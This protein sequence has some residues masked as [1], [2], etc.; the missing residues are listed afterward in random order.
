MYDIFAEKRAIIPELI[1]V[2]MQICKCIC[3]PL[4]TGK[5]SGLVEYEDSRCVAT[6][7][8]SLIGNRFLL[9]APKF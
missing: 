3:I 4:D 6:P 1:R 7:G 2:D 8:C 5:Q 9:V